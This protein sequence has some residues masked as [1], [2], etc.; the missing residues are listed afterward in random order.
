MVSTRYI[1]YLVKLIK[2]FLLWMRISK[3]GDDANNEIFIKLILKE[4]G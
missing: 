2:V 3:E 4:D 1:N